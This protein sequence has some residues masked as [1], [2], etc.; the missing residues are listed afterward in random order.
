MH[1]KIRIIIIKNTVTLLKSFKNFRIK[2]KFRITGNVGIRYNAE[3][4]DTKWQ[5][6]LAFY[7]R[8]DA[9]Y[10]VTENIPARVSLTYL[11]YGDGKADGTKISDSAVNWLELSVATGYTITEGVTPWIELGYNLMGTNTPAELSIRVFVGFQ[12]FGE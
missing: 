12:I 6:G 10:A 7:L 5:P 2:I 1:Q 4:S 11:N 8:G 9:Y 3:D